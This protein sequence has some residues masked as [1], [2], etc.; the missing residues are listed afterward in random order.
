MLVTH[1]PDI[2]AFAARVIS[3]QDGRVRIDRTQQPADARRRCAASPR[4]RS[5]A[6]ARARTANRRRA[7]DRRCRR[8]GSRAALLRNKLRSFLT[9]LGIIIGVAAVIAMV[10]I[11]E[12]A[13]ALVE[14]AFAA[15]G[16]NL[17]IVMSGDHDVGRRARRLRIDADAHL[18]RSGARSSARCRRVQYAAPQLRTTRQVVTEETNWTTSVTG[19]TPE[20][21]LI[22]S[23]PIASGA[24][25]TQ[26]DVDGGDQGRRPRPDRRRQAVRRRRRPGRPDVRIRNVPFQVVGVL[27]RKGQSPMGQD[28]DDTVFIP[29]TTYH[30]EDPGRPARSTC[31]AR[32]WSSAR[33]R[34][35][36]RRPQQQITALLRDA[37]TCRAADD[38]FSIRNLTE[39]ASAQQEGTKTLTTLLASIAAVS[40]LVGGIGIMNIMLVSVTERT[41][42]IG[43]R[44]AVGAQPRDILTAVPGRGAGAVDRGR[45]R[46]RRGRAGRSRSSSRR[47]SAGRC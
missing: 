46:R 9:T 39:M 35:R 28:Y 23:W 21:F 5:G 27:A 34:T 4:E 13:K 24:T 42:E 2:A 1:E 11:G 33:R 20:Y 30:G 26:S 36:R 22:R 41:R 43:M 14:Q 37:T 7:H 3:V 6:R 31:R 44:M 15:M 16:T 45:H 18:G 25:F 47:A 32:S 17:L 40:L 10:A 12:G 19:T 8:S 29:S 38:D